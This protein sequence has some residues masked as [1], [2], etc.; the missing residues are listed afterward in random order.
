MAVADFSGMPVGTW[1]IETTVDGQPAGRFTIEIRG[2]PVVAAL[3]KRPLAQAEL[4]ERLNKSF[5]VIERTGPRGRALDPAA[6][7][8]AGAGRLH[9]PRCR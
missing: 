3:V 9:V 7:F 2:E 6:G 8:V 4:Y 5:V 1:S